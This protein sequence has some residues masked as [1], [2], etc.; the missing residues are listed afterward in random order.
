MSAERT[1]RR[2]SRTDGGLVLGVCAGLAR[3]WHLERATVR[4]AFLITLLP[5]GAGLLL[6][7]A[8]ALVMPG[9]DATEHE[10]G[11]RAELGRSL[12]HAL[13]VLGGLLVV[14]TIA[15]AG[16]T[17][18]IF[19]LSP[20]V[21]AL[22]TALLV[23]V[24]VLDA[25]RVWM[26]GVALLALA[27]PAAAIALT[28][29][30]VDRQFGTRVAMPTTA[31]EV[32]PAGYRTGTGPLLIDL[33]QFDADAG[34]TTTIRAHA[35]LRELVVAL[36]RTRCFNLVVDY[37]VDQHWLGRALDAA[38][39]DGD[40]VLGKAALMLGTR[41][42]A[43]R[44]GLTAYGVDLPRSAGRYERAVA[45]RS[46]PT[47]HLGLTSR[48]S[49]IVVRD[50]PQSVG[51]L[52]QPDWPANVQPLK[53]PTGL[54]VAAWVWDGE[55]HQPVLRAPE[56]RAA[57]EALNLAARSRTAQRELRTLERIAK[58]RAEYP[59]RQAARMAGAC[60]RP[61]RIDALERRLAAE[62]EAAPRDPRTQT[63]DNLAAVD[64]TLVAKTLP[65]RIRPANRTPR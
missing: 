36:P 57:V 53:F 8:L 10:A 35:E 48:R 16:A 51:P 18:A 42:S 56:P 26:L 50:F 40:D 4:G 61:A 47:L 58:S 64:R 23:G 20:I 25:R 19:G 28:D 60:A 1:F 52:G 55:G 65:A 41:P 30:Q 29:V 13:L 31:A 21:L 15:A 44:A 33:R 45:D 5:F 43:Q 32:D 59:R 37:R 22:A 49:R 34:T 9:D 14:I 3:R 17:L 62:A 54:E 38:S 27:V 6:Y 7:A 24:L 63:L 11:W 2:P 12:L 39:V 46:A